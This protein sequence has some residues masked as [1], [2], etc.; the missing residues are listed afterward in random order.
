MRRELM[1][2]R[3]VPGSTLLQGTSVMMSVLIFNGTSGRGYG[4]QNLAVR[5]IIFF[6]NT[7]SGYKL[8]GVHNRMGMKLASKYNGTLMVKSKLFEL[9][10]GFI[11]LHAAALPPPTV[12]QA[13]CPHSS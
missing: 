3:W 8:V 11:V 1:R 12:V 13:S 4:L 9:I 2:I 6:N 10:K 7:P 5:S